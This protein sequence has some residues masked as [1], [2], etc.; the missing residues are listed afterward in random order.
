M[1]AFISRARAFFHLAW[2]DRSQARAGR[3]AA[4]VGVGCGR[5][6][7]AE[8][9][10]NAA[11]RRAAAADELGGERV[12]ACDARRGPVRAQ[13]RGEGGRPRAGSF[14]TKSSAW[15]TRGQGGQRRRG[16][17]SSSDPG[18]ACPWWYVQMREAGRT[19]PGTS[20][21]ATSASPLSLSLA[22]F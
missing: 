13:V 18:E 7:L 10:R 19:P 17:L 9:A 8:A 5:C 12:F 11:A 2:L 4:P 3:V 16:A 21:H 1:R 14:E 22:G 6:S 15:G 20:P